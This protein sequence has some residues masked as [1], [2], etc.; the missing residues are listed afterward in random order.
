[1]PVNENDFV[2]PA[3]EPDREFIQRHDTKYHR[4]L[5]PP[6]WRLLE[7]R[8]SEVGEDIVYLQKLNGSKSEGF[9]LRRFLPHK[10]D[11]SPF[12]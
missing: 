7:V 8:L 6:P 10:P 3:T 1:M 11:L 9:F 2:I 12:L 4:V 5:G